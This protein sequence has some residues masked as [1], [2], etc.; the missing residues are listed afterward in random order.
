[1][2]WFVFLLLALAGAGAV[3]IR[4]LPWLRDRP[5]LLPLETEWA[6][7]ARTGQPLPEYPR[8]QLRRTRWQNLNGSWDFAVQPR[9]ADRPD[10]FSEKILVP[11][12]VESALSGVGR[13]VLPEERAWYRRTFESPAD[14]SD[15]LLLHFGAVDYEAE[16]WVNDHRIGE[17]SGGFDPFSF[18]VTDALSAEGPQ[19]VVVAVWDPTN[20]GRQPRGKQSLR[21]KSIWY[22]AVTGIWQTVWLEPVSE[23]RIERTVATTDLGAK[24]IT[25]RTRLT[26]VLP[27]DRLQVEI[28]GEGDTAIAEAVVPA[29]G[30]LAQ[31]TFH[32]PDLR[33]WSP[34]DPHLYD[35]RLRLLRDGDAVDDARSYFGAREITT[36]KDENG[37]WRLLLNGASVFSLGLLDQGWWPDGLYTAPSDE[38]L[39]FDIE[40]TR[41]MGFNTIRKHVKVEPA[42]W[43]W[44]ADRLGVLVWQD[45]PT[46]G[47]KEHHSIPKEIWWLV[48]NT[49]HAERGYDL[50]RSPEEAA[51]YRRELNAMIDLLE[52][53]PS[54]VIWVPFNESWGQFDTDKILAEVK[55]R[56]PSRLVDGPSGW[57]DTGSGD[58]RD[59]HTYFREGK[60]PDL[61]P[62]RPMVYG[63]FGGLAHEVSGHLGVAKGFGYAV[64]KDRGEFADAYAK[65]LGIIAKLKSRGLAGAI[66]TQTTDVEGEINGLLTYDRAVFKIP[67]ER[68]REI[69][70][71]L[72]EEPE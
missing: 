26:A 56:D 1:M 20:E 61:E 5:P 52:P 60:Q 67:P 69:H 70:R 63:E 43:Y 41:R 9:E 54:V 8:P 62:D 10:S 19:E 38:A 23:S 31:H 55:T 32:L 44:H 28:L 68:L 29:S 49:P 65:K 47:P 59:H 53:F 42:R 40:A 58:L 50:T 7:A 57:V 22:T 16:V 64:F 2:L 11:F 45:M 66:Y 18:D 34:D 15:R 36:A 25:L 12:P 4:L 33:P 71:S 21:P 35:I 72:T 27:G 51:S 13:A 6:D 14:S 24:S 37:T 39:A 48:V 3:Y 30:D 17:H 46:G